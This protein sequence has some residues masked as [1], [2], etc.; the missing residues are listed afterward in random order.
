LSAKE[1]HNP[2]TQTKLHNALDS[3]N[4]HYIIRLLF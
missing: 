4:T 2:A 1:L 3:T